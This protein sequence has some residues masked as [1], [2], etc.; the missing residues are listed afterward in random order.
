MSAMHDTIRRLFETG[1]YGRIVEDTRHF[2]L[3]RRTDSLLAVLVAHASFEAGAQIAHTHWLQ[4]AST[5]HS[6]ESEPA[7]NSFSRSA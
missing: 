4:D 2:Q 7:P 3:D 6:R 1:E 5:P